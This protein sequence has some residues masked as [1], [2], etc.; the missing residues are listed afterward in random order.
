[1]FI[2]RIQQQPIL[3]TPPT[4][5]LIIPKTGKIGQKMYDR[6]IREGRRI[7]A[8]ALT[9]YLQSPLQFFLKYIADIK[10]PPSISQ[11]FEMNKLG[12]VIHNVMESILRPY[13][14]NAEFTPTKVLLDK[15]ADI[16]QLTLTEIGRQYHTVFHTMEELNS[17]QRIMHKIASAY[18]K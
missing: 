13:K 6:F 8:T 5:E 7:S 17:L 1:R 2:K 16:D 4:D 12:T 9:T 11:E 18:V 10:E 14:G 3:F 15:I